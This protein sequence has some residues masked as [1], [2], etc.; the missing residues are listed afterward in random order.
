MLG[1]RLK[2]H[3]GSAGVL[4]PGMEARLLKHDNA[5]PP[6]SALTSTENDCDVNEEGDLWLRSQ[7]IA[8]GYWNNP[9]ANSETFVGGWLRT[10]DRFRVD[11]HGNFW[12]ADRAKVSCLSAPP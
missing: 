1:G 2:R 7:N 5:V 4:L 11:E 9:K 12:F 6:S 8:I 10:G 3:K